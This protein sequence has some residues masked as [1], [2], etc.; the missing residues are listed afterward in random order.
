MGE[1]NKPKK[2][3]ENRNGYLLSQIIFSSV[4]QFSRSVVS[5]SLGPHGLQYANKPNFLLEFNKSQATCE[6]MNIQ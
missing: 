2:I 3:K 5:N 4:S 6:V 1:T